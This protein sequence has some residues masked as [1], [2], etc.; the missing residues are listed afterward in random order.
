MKKLFVLAL[1]VVF[2]VFAATI[3][4]AD[5][6]TNFQDGKVEITFGADANTYTGFATSVQDLKVR[7]DLTK[8]YNEQLSAGVGMKYKNNGGETGWDP[9]GWIKFNYGTLVV[10]AKTDVGGKAGSSDELDLWGCAFGLPSGPG[11]QVDYSGIKGLNVTLVAN[12]VTATYNHGTEATTDDY[13]A[14][15]PNYLAKATFATGPVSVGAGY[16]TDGSYID[17]FN[18]DVETRKGDAV[19]AWGSFKVGEIATISGEYNNRIDIKASAILAKV[20]ATVGPLSLTGKFLNSAG[21]FVTIPG[22]AAD[23]AIGEDFSAIGSVEAFGWR[24]NVVYGEANFKVN[25]KIS[26]G[27][28]GSYILNGTTDG[29]TPIAVALSYKANASFQA[30]EKIKLEAWYKAYGDVSNAAGKVNYNWAGGL[31]TNLEVGI[32]NLETMYYKATVTAAL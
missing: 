29:T 13:S 20:D 31:D 24:A 14:T 23:W 8:V 7:F 2:M 1:T 17:P 22:W 16:Q 12:D 26:V 25:D 27:G 3:C 30:T 11:V 5:G 18:G 21:G 19:A 28:N 6:T 32:N 4:M 15:R 9:T 10:Q